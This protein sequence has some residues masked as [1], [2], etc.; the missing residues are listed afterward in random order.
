[1]WGQTTQNASPTEQIFTTSD[2]TDYLWYITNV[3]TKH[4]T[5][6]L[7]LNNS[8]DWLSVFVDGN[9][10]GKTQKMNHLNEIIIRLNFVDRFS[11]LSRETSIQ[12]NKLVSKF[13]V[14]VKK[15][16]HQK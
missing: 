16:F 8:N 12:A 4:E 2:T 10:I 6:S 5:N 7:T 3:T 15:P 13:R 14:T 1:M 9:W 11:R